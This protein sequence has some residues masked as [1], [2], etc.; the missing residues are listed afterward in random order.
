MS[1]HLGVKKT[2]EKTLQRFYWYALKEDITVY[3][4][5]CDVCAAVKKPAKTP[6]APLGHLPAGAPGD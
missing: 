1:G 2:K 6:R 4:Q 3:I 5:K